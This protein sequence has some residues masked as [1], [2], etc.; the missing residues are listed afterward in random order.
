MNISNELFNFPKSKN[1]IIAVLIILSLNIFVNYIRIDL[2]Y[3]FSSGQVETLFFIQENIPR[4]ST[5]LVP[6]LGKK[7]Y[8]YDLLIDYKFKYMDN[9]KEHLYDNVRGS[10][11]SWKVKYLVIDISVINR[12]QL[13]LFLNDHIFEI[14]YNNTQNIL[15]VYKHPE[16]SKDK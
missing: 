13:E 16:F 11:Y 8:L 15:F 3:D 14:L 9:R 5:I 10:L 12:K 6:D 1:V 2:Y 4:N 7:N